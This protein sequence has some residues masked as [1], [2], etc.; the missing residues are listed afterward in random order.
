MQIL[1]TIPERHRYNVV[2]PR[3]ATSTQKLPVLYYYTIQ[4]NKGIQPAATPMHFL[5]RLSQSLSHN[6]KYCFTMLQYNTTCIKM[7]FFYRELLW[8]NTMG[9]PIRWV[10]K[11]LDNKDPQK[12]LLRDSTLNTLT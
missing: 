7:I 3:W 6:H 11:V 8:E 10:R 4:Q 2:H 12:H 9:H 1:N 5:F